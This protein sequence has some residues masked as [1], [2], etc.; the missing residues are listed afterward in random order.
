MLCFIQ[1]MMSSCN[2]SYFMRHHQM[3]LKFKDLLNAEISQERCLKQVL[4]LV[5][6]DYCVILSPRHSTDNSKRKF[7]SIAWYRGMCTALGHCRQNI[8][9]ATPFWSLFPYSYFIQE[10]VVFG[11]SFNHFIL[12]FRPSSYLTFYFLSP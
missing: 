7:D 1:F 5:R 4:V 3:L 11:G 9:A 10:G 6:G 12:R 8:V 2:N